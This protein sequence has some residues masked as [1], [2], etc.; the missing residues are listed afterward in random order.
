MLID[1]PRFDHPLHVPLAVIR[2]SS[3]Q[4]F[5]MEFIQME[6]DDQKRLRE[7]IQAIK[8]AWV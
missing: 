6:P 1:V 7:L 3:G 2:W 5:G 4:E 8:T